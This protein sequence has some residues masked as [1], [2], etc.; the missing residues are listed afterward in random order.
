LALCAEAADTTDSPE[1]GPPPVSRFV[2]TDPT[3]IEPPALATTASEP[4]PEP[5]A[6][7]LPEPAVSVVVSNPEKAKASVALIQSKSTP[8]DGDSFGKVEVKLPP[9][10]T[11]K[12]GSKRK[13][14]TSDNTNSTRSE[15]PVSDDARAKSIADRPIIGRQSGKSLK[16][17]V[18]IR[19]EA[20]EAKEAKEVK[21]KLSATQL[22]KPLASRSPNEAVTSPKKA[23]SK[24]L[25]EEAASARSNPLKNK[26]RPRAQ[27]VVIPTVVEIPPLPPPA[28]IE[29]QPEPEVTPIPAEIFSPMSPEPSEPQDSARDTPPPADISSFGETSRPNRRARAA[30]SYA[31]PNLRDKMRRPTKD[32]V[33][34]VGGKAN[35]RLSM[36]KDDYASAVEPSP[37]MSGS[38]ANMPLANSMQQLETSSP[39][40][41][42]GDVLV[43]AI[44][45]RKK[46]TSSV[47]LKGTNEEYSNQ[48]KQDLKPESATSTE[49]ND[50]TTNSR[51][52]NGVDLYEFTTS[53]PVS[54][55]K[56]AQDDG[57]KGSLSRQSKSSRRLSSVVREDLTFRDI[58]ISERPRATASRKRA[59]MAAPK[60]TRM[61]MSLS[62]ESSPDSSI[63]GEG[64]SADDKTYVP[65]R[66]SMRRRSMML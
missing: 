55:L 43:P 65:E 54:E 58:E 16:E 20:R 48:I 50:K 35:G 12:S 26:P 23:T 53:S 24:G 15:T 46:R 7:I 66:V 31:E 1:L 8:L 17:L 49:A 52:A 5:V 19:R 51:A 57:G 6:S 63:L 42:N 11:I 45:E 28:P 38:V 10:L 9:A 56:G 61:D 44:A 18:N 21:E 2:D 13:F 32:L 25:K 62:E 60:R 14:S 29:I 41:Q 27:A 3:K 33:D 39:R 30:I 22:R 36:A 4:E 34:A 64:G 40:S 59:S 47:A 37:T